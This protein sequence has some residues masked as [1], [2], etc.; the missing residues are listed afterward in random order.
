MRNQEGSPRGPRTQSFATSE[1]SLE[2]RHPN[3][4]G[5]EPRKGNQV[6]H[7]SMRYSDAHSSSHLELNNKSESGD[8]GQS[9]SLQEFLNVGGK[10][11]SPADSKCEGETAPRGRVTSQNSHPQRDL[12]RALPPIQ[13]RAKLKGEIKHGKAI[14][15]GAEKMLTDS[16]GS[17]AHDQLSE[18]FPAFLQKMLTKVDLEFSKLNWWVQQ[19]L[20]LP[21]R[22][23]I[24]TFVMRSVSDKGVGSEGECDEGFGNFRRNRVRYALKAELWQVR[25]RL[26]EEI[27][28]SSQVV[29][30]EILQSLKI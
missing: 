25:L 23:K 22:D 4:E 8:F 13:E 27:D 5:D 17:E 6:D 16:P 15:S 20:L 28:K 14:P 30:Q 24:K 7:D 10:T 12:H 26:F 21:Q 18:G 3:S 2:G 1:E 9:D 19:K 11:S 29:I